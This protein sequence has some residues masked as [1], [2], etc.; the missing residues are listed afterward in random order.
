M[1]R[2]ILVSLLVIT[3][4]QSSYGHGGEKHSKKEKKTRSA[5]GE[6]EKTVLNKVNAN[7]V[8]MIE[9][10]FRKKCLDCHGTGNSMPW[11]FKVPVAK[12][13]ME[14]DMKEAKEHMDMSEGF[15]FGGHGTPK[16]DLEELKNVVESEEMPPWQYRLIHWSSNLN[17]KEKEVVLLWINNSIELLRRR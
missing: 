11:Y 3:S 14:Y 9:P 4:W 12:Q 15:P 5:P 7:Y 10:I 17:A 16:E 2:I 13:I 6:L 8:K 1:I